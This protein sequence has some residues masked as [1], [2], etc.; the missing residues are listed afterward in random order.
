MSEQGAAA[1][2]PTNE[3]VGTDA[4]VAGVVGA[5]AERD[6]ELVDVLA[7]TIGDAESHA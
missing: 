1:H 3:R 2:L 5:L 4:R 7:E 6:D